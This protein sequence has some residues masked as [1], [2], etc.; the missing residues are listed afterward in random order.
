M[1]SAH[2]TNGVAEDEGKSGGFWPAVDASFLEV[3]V[4][5]KKTTKISRLTML[6]FS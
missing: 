5:C 3:W 1:A 4:N 6:I 2:P